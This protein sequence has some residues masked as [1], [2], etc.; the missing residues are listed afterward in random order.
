MHIYMYVCMCI[1]V[2]H[3]CAQIFTYT[4]TNMQYTYEHIYAYIRVCVQ[5]SMNIKH[6]C[7]YMY[8]HV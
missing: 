3:T 4:H 2:A 7:L 8:T 6:M 1:Y 5:I